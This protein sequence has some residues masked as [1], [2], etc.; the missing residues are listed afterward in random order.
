MLKT[1][2][3]LYIRNGLSKSVFVISCALIVKQH[4]VTACRNYFVTRSLPNALIPRR[5]GRHEDRRALVLLVWLDAF[6]ILDSA[7][8]GRQGH[9]LDVYH[10]VTLD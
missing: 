1:L 3:H 8:D 7:E 5:V 9:F 2:T 4:F 6:L 10:G